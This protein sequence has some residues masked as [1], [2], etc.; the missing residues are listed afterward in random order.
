M[1]NKIYL[2]VIAILTLTEVISI[3]IPSLNAYKK[4]T[5]NLVTQKVEPITL[6]SRMMLMNK[7]MSAINALGYR[8]LDI[9]LKEKND[10]A[11]R[12]EE[13]LAY[14]E[15]Y[16]VSDSKYM[17]TT[18]NNWETKHDYGDFKYIDSIKCIRFNQMTKDIAIHKTEDSLALEYKRLEKNELK[19]LNTSCK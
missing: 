5:E 18:S 13:D 7:S 15:F 1:K 6:E 10:S 8:S 12:K 9:F 4:Y 2:I 14:A 19:S 3:G 11:L 17:L 16:R